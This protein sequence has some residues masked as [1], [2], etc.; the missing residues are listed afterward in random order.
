MWGTCGVP[1]FLF[2]PQAPN[3]ETQ[4]KVG[5]INGVHIA[6]ECERGGGGGVNMGVGQVKI[7]PPSRFLVY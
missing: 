4:D 3:C 1:D 6:V 7:S 5:Q 2:W